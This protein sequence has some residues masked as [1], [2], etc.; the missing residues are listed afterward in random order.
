MLILSSPSF[1]QK[2]QMFTWKNETETISLL[3]SFHVNI[4]NPK[5]LNVSFFH[6]SFFF[7]S[8]LALLKKKVDVNARG[9]DGCNSLHILCDMRDR[10]EW[11]RDYYKCI[12]RL[13]SLNVDV[14]AK[15][16][17]SETGE[18]D[19]ICCIFLLTFTVSTSSRRIERKFESYGDDPF[20]S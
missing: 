12:Q 13:I 9:N 1:N 15:N 10:N 11:K 17:T 7:F 5:C 16:D 4:T 8:I 2:K 6:S 20:P 18:K 3:F 14:T 19:W